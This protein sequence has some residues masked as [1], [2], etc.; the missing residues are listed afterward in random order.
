MHLYIVL[1][2]LLPPMDSGM[3]NGYNK[4]LAID[5]TLL[6][7]YYVVA[8]YGKGDTCLGFNCLFT[9]VK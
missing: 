7:G 1:I 5:I 8:C 3:I 2:N 4:A 9:T 6:G